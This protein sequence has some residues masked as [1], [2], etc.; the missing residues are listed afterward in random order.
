MHKITK[1]DI[2][3]SVGRGLIIA[4]AIIGATYFIGTWY[5]GASDLDS[6]YQSLDG[7]LT[8]HVE[9]AAA[10]ALTDSVTR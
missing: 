4:A 1:A 2:F 7:T 6:I 3:F 10:P 9:H 5:L 8:S